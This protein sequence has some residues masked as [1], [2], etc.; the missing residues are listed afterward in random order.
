[1]TLQMY[2]MELFKNIEQATVFYQI[3]ARLAKFIL[4]LILFFCNIGSFYF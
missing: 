4:I 2:G 1:M 3:L